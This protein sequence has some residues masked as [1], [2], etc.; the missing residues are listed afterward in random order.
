M[1]HPYRRAKLDEDAQRRVAQRV[2]TL[3][4]VSIPRGVLRKGIN[5]VAIEVIR[6]PYHKVM[7][8][9]TAALKV[10]K[11]EW[12]NQATPYDLPWNTC[13]IVSV[14]LKA[15]SPNG[16]TPNAARPKGLQVWNSDVLAA[17]FDVDFGDRCEAVRPVTIVAARNGSFSGKVVVGSS[18]P[19]RGLTATPTDLKGSAGTIPAS[20]VRIRYALPWGD[21]ASMYSRYEPAYPQQAT[22]LGALCELPLDVYAVRDKQ[23]DRYW[24]KTPGEPNAVPGAVVPVWVT[25]RVPP[26]AAPGDYSGQLT[27][28][29]EGQKPLA[30]PIAIKV[31]DWELPGSQD[32]RTWVEVIQSPDTLAVEYKLDQWSDRHFEL[33]AKSFGFLNEVGSRVLYVPL[34]CG[35]NLG[36]EQSMVRWISK[37]GGYEHD[38]SVMDRYLDLAEKHM[39]KPKIV[40]FIVWDVYLF[41]KDLKPQGGFAGRF[42]RDGN[43]PL[44]GKGPLVTTLDP[45]TGKTAN[46]HLSLYGDP[47]AKAP[48]ESLFAKL[49]DR[50]K[51]RGLDQAMMLGFV[52]DV[53]PTKEELTFFKEVTGDLPWVMHSHPPYRPGRTLHGLAAVG[54]NTHVRRNEYRTDPAGK[55]LYGWRRP[56]LSAQYQRDRGFE[57]APASTWRHVQEINITGAQRGIGRVGGD[58]WPAV[59]DKRN[60]RQGAV[61]QRYPQSSWS[62]LNLYTSLLAPGPNGPV[63][64]THFEAFREG[65]QECEARIFIERALTDE[66]LKSRLGADLAQ[67]AQQTLDARV[68]PMW[69]SLCTFQL[70]GRDDN[71]ATRLGWGRVPGIAGHYWFLGSGWQKRSEELYSLA[72]AV[73]GKLPGKQPAR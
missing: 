21:E 45:Q 70:T 1:S 59:R 41:P 65:V 69:R 44:A 10:N 72:A 2:R 57:R 54:Y 53:W 68:L 37:G 62:N 49:R 58:F 60:R 30:V 7:D 14:R 9:I 33:M 26:G 38:F 46:A 13:E 5:V 20:A 23:D 35:T 31:L 36:N 64:T 63:A 4:E 11:A 47:R 19:I 39:G 12:R 71:Y 67:R 27:V 17:D 8:E 3:G 18:E 24:R 43:D 32:Y 48:W 16:L 6:A 50:M 15:Q 73:A 66:K 29:A 25:V 51:R 56:D 28:R 22:M 55:R 40:A 61:W 34:I 52:T 42:V